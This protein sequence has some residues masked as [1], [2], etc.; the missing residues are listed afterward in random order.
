MR[1]AY[2]YITK[3]GCPCRVSD[4]LHHNYVLT[5]A[6]ITLDGKGFA[7]RDMLIVQVIPGKRSRKQAYRT[8]EAYIER[9]LKFRNAH[10]KPSL[11]DEW[12]QFQQAIAPGD[13]QI[14]A[15]YTRGYQPPQTHV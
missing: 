9:T 8:C 1:V 4:R 5:P 3:D 14:K 2:Y 13:F 15:V 11:V 12:V 6:S 7:W 10:S